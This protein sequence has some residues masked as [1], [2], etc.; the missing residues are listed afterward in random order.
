MPLEKFAPVHRIH[1]PLYAGAFVGLAEVDA[2]PALVFALRG[3]FKLRFPL[4][5]LL[6]QLVMHI[7][8]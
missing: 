1:F 7:T 2:L 5:E 3:M 6:R 8:P 4:R